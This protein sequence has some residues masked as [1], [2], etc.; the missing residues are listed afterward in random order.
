[1]Q[2]QL[3]NSQI[4]QEKKSL[5]IFYEKVAEGLVIDAVRKVQTQ[6]Q[7]N[8]PAN[9]LV[10]R[11]QFIHRIPVTHTTLEGKSQRSSRLCAEKSK[12]QTS[13]TAKKCTINANPSDD[14]QFIRGPSILF[15][16]DI[17]FG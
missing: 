4:N 3:G 17:N 10:G 2:R 7:T 6:G 16:L 1:M 15:S 12:I 14:A 8:R 9:R 5:E 11:E 13:K